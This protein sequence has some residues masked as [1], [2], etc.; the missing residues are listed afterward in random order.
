[1]PSC[2]VKTPLMRA[3]TGGFLPP[4]LRKNSVALPR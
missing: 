4:L 3:M 2:C 1:M